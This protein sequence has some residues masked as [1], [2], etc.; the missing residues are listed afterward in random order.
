MLEDREIRRLILATA[1]REEGSAEAFEALYRKSA[2]LLLGI[3]RR[4]LGRRE[5]AEEI[6]H[7]SFVRIWHSAERFDPTGGQPLAWMVAIVRNRAIDVLQSHEVSRVDALDLDASGEDLDALFDWAAD[8]ESGLDA[9]RASRALRDCLAGLQAAER[10][11][12]VLAYA[13]GMSHGE[14]AS[15]LRKPLGTVKG[16]I[17]RGLANLRQCVERRAEA[18]R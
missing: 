4:I 7:D 11:S 10:Q 18:V 1:A 17:R 5:L 3:A 15:H 13:H 2:P 6:V 12:L 14:L 9:Q 8:P 16:W